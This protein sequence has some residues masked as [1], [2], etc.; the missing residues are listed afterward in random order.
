MIKAIIFDCFGVLT[1]ESFDAFRN[2]YFTNDPAKRQRANQAMEQLNSAQISYGEFL[3]ALTDL[4]GLTEEKVEHY[5]SQNT[6]NKPLFDYIRRRLKPKY[7]IGVLSNAGSN[8][9]NELFA[10]KT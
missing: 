9:L 10:K 8:W 7:K 6:A 5:L 2:E 1:T 4:S 3:A